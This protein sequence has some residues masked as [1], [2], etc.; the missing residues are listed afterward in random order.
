MDNIIVLN[1]NVK[2]ESLKNLKDIVKPQSKT[3]ILT[4]QYIFENEAI[5]I[6]SIFDCKCI[7]KNF[8]DILTDAERE[9]CDKDAF[10]PQKQG[11]DV[12][13]YYHDIKKLKNQRL[14][15]KLLHQHS[16]SN[17]II[18]ADGLGI[19]KNEWCE[20]GFIYYELDYYYPITKSEINKFQ[21]LKKLLRK[22]YHLILKFA[23][24]LLSPINQAFNTQ[25]HEAYKDGTRYL[26]YGKLT[27][28]GYRID[29]EFHKAAFIEHIYYLLNKLG[30][31]WR[32]KTVRLSS[33]H[34]GYHTIPDKKELNVKLIQDGYLPPNYS[35]NYL[36]FFGRNTEFYTWDE[37]GCNTFRYHHLPHRIMPFRK[38]LFLPNNFKFPNK[39]KKVLCASSGTGD[40]TA[41]KNRSDDDRLVWAIGQAAK[42][43]P[44]I[45]FI[46]RCH[47]TWIHPEHA[48]VNS[49]NRCAQ[50]ISWLNLPNF[51]ISSNIPTSQENGHLILSYKRSSFEEDL[52]D[53]DLVFGEHSV[54][55]L[56]AGFKGI[57]FAS[58]NMTGHRA[59]Y[60]DIN[61]L[62][63]PH[64]ESV[65]DIVNLLRTLP[66][67]EVREQYTQ[68]I[69]EYNKMTE[70][71]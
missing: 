12:A 32:N 36:Y 61:K 56:D 53:V 69:I 27:R 15:E 55:M 14:I 1:Q 42:I 10:N 13:V 52:K 67:I 34:E 39:V 7:Y 54:A 29:L 26:F 2:L 37:I 45:E 17:K 28:I 57:P 4:T 66:T 22:P 30:F 60:E 25:I 23:N 44:D 33:F 3:L 47:P 38:K 49:I 46:Y 40:W 59:Y 50:Y 41:I 9:K 18:V 43:F 11:Q 24:R 64:C 62:G 35:S 65:E 6:D 58:C 8:G 51:K 16:F 21:L 20:K 68:A 71:D 31:V 70:I 48:G 5:I 63:F 19:S